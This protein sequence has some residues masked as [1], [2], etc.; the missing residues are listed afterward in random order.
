MKVGDKVTELCDGN[1]VAA[2]TVE[3]ILAHEIRTTPG[4]VGHR[5]W[6]PESGR[7]VWTSHRR[8]RAWRDTD[9][10]EIA[11]ARARAS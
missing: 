10:R 2:L 6:L 5:R 9:P 11:D 4:E 3:R 1:P 8:I 7:A